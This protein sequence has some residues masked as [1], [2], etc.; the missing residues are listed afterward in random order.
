[1]RDFDART[2]RLRE[3]TLTLR[4]RIH[5]AMASVDNHIPWDDIFD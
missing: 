4:W 5:D 3:E 1:M 2:V